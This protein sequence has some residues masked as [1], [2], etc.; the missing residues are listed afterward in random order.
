MWPQDSGEG[1]L[2]SNRQIRE[3][4][5]EVNR[6]CP[7]RCLHCSSN[8]GPDA[9]EKLDPFKVADLIQ[10]F[11]H[12]GGQTLAISGG[13]PLLYEGLPH[14]L[15]VCHAVGIRPN[16]YT[17]GVCSNGLSLDP[18]ADD[19]LRLISQSCAKVIFSVHGAQAQPHDMLTQVA[20]SFETTIEAIRRT[21]SAGISTEIH[22]VPTAI[23]F[24]ELADMVRL[25]ASMGIEKVS[26]L[27]FVP[28]G[29]GAINRD[30]LQLT[31]EQLR[32]LSDTKNELEHTHPDIRI[33]TGSPFNILCPQ[34]PTPCTAGLSVLAV[35][36][37]G[38]VVPC[39]AFKQF[40]IPDS[41]SNILDHSLSEVW[42]K[43]E[44]LSAVRRTWEARYN[45][46]CASCPAFPHC[47]SGCLAQ[48]AV[49]AGRLTDSKDPDCL[50]ERAE[51]DSG[52]IE[53]I[54]VC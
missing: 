15:S 7:L 54:P 47:N 23:N 53:A 44:L 42:E 25:L 31:K 48:K 33:R 52:E 10:Q 30:R 14:I 49:A 9:P 50:L 5:V 26:W 29:R 18:I 37:D 21:L 16:F 51:V 24:R 34:S 6:E 32:R 19:T 3:L 40:S 22:V 43:S 17:T 45:S 38:R 12:L 36:P 4:K 27:R 11:A 1:T 28:Q 13:E 20:G 39:D 2:A 41:F 8:G 46:P 35:R